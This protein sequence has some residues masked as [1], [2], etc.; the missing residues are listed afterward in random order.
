[1]SYEWLVGAALLIGIGAG[2]ISPAS[3]NAGLQL[4]PDR[5]ATLAALRTMSMQ[6]GTIVTV[7]VATA[8]IATGR[9]AGAAEAWIFAVVAATL[10]VSIPIV[11]WI[12]EHRG[13]W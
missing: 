6:I 7:S 9:D 10:A 12:P 11:N 13:T 8:F 5:S 2:A 4:E 1:P 3:R